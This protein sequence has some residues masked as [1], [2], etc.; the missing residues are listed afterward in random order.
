LPGDARLLGLVP[1]RFHF[2][3]SCCF[4]AAKLAQLLDELD[5]GHMRFHVVCCKRPQLL[6][7]RSIAHTFVTSRV[8]VPSIQRQEANPLE[9]RATNSHRCCPSFAFP[10]S[11]L[12]LHPVRHTHTQNFPCPSDPDAHSCSAACLLELGATPGT[13]STTA[14]GPCVDIDGKWETEGKSSSC[15]GG[16]SHHPIPIAPY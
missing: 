3:S 4:N 12:K 9:T 11:R 15:I 10:S 6:Q 7:A 1:I 13:L 16:L 2:C 8:P 14:E 5:P